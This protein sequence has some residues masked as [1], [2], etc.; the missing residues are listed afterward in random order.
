MRKVGYTEATSKAG[1]QYRRLRKVTKVFFDENSIKRDIKKANKMC[2]KAED[3]TNLHRNL[4][5][6]AR[7]SG[8]L[9]PDTSVIAPTN[10]VIIDKTTPI[11]SIDTQAQ[12]NECKAIDDR[13]LP[14]ES[15]G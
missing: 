6:Q 2:I 10:L 12:S 13:Q 15:E 8:L 1:N 11:Q 9:K 7:V 4:E 14:P 3:I 5:L